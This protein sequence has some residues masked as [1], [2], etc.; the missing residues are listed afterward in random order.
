MA[1]HNV[2]RGTALA[3]CLT[4]AACAGPTYYKNGGTP[5]SFDRDAYACERES[6]MAA[7]IPQSI[8]S[9]G[10][11][12]YYADPTLGWA[13]VLQSWGLYGRCMKAMGWTTR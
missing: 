11:Y 2:P 1:L 10:N 7:R 4:L 13:S 5:E 12:T 6:A 8:T 3:L 9:V